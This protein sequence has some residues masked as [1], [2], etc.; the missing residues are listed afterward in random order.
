VPSRGDL[1]LTPQGNG[2]F[3]RS[4]T[5]SAYLPTARQLKLYGK[6]VDEGRGAKNRHP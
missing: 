2:R 4:T 1:G 6:G 3:Q 5:S